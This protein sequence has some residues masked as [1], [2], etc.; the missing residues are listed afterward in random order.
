M[1]HFF[2]LAKT[3]LLLI[4]LLSGCVHGTSPKEEPDEIKSLS[5][6]TDVN[7]YYLKQSDETIDYANKTTSYLG[8][9]QDQLSALGTA[10][11]SGDD[12]ATISLTNNLIA[13]GLIQQN[14]KAPDPFTQL[15]DLHHSYVVALQELQEANEQVDFEDQQLHYGYAQLTLTLWS[16]EYESLIADYGIKAEEE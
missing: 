15:P 12:A 4:V 7:H 5:N 16:R 10:I 6:R 9:V 3:A 1:R 2:T 14:F 8:T 11:E 13:E